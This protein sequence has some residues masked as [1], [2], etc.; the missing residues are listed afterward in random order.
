MKLPAKQLTETLLT[1]NPLARDDD[2]IFL[3]EYLSF[4]GIE[5]N[6][7]DINA[8]KN[9]YAWESLTRERRTIQNTEKRL[10]ATLDTQKKRKAREVSMRIEKAP[11]TIVEPAILPKRPIRYEFQGNVAIPIYQ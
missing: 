9:G 11:K 5:L 4:L 7:F 2:R 6:M 8:I 10:Q 1:R 3:I